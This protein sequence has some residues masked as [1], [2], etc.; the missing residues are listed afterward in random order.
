MA[1]VLGEHVYEA[2]LRNKRHEW[3]DYRVEITPYELRRYLTG[4]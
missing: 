1:E 4:L 3:D 2:L